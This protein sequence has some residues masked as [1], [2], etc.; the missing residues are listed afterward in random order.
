MKNLDFFRFDT[1][2][3][4]ANWNNAESKWEI[5]TC[6]KDGLEETL[7]A[8]HM[9]SACGFLRHP[10]IPDFKGRETFQGKSF[11]SARWDT[12]YDFEGKRVAVIGTGSSAVQIIP[13]M[14]PPKVS[15][16]YVFQRSSNWHYPRDD[17]KNPDWLKAALKV[18]PGLVGTLIRSLLFFK[19]ESFIPLLFTNKFTWLNELNKWMIK[20]NKKFY[21]FLFRQ[22]ICKCRNNWY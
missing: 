22:Q 9:V 11:H 20:G 3:E 13:A 6:S 14:A 8:S 1:S 21:P 19:Y 4:S 12:S 7:V 2:V 17:F 10:K 15:Q 16:L 5:K 18:A